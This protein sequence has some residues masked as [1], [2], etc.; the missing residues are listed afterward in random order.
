MTTV[1]LAEQVQPGPTSDS[2]PTG[3]RI[4]S[5][6]R[7]GCWICRDKKVKKKCDQQR[8]RC[9]RCV[10]HK[11]SCDYSPR[12]TLAERRRASQDIVIVQAA[13]DVPNDTTNLLPA[14]PIGLPIV[15]GAWSRNLST[16]DKEAIAYFRTG[17]AESHHTKNPDYGL[18]SL[19]FRIAQQEEMVMHM[20]IAIG[21]HEMDFRRLRPTA[22]QT[23][24]RHYATALRL[25]AVAITSPEKAKDTDSIYTTL[26]LMLLYEQQFGDAECRAYV[27]H[28]EGISSLLQHQGGRLLTL[29]PRKPGTVNRTSGFLG[30][31]T[32][33]ATSKMSVYSARVLVWIAL[34]DAAAASSGVG[35]QVNSTILALMIGDTSTPKVQVEDPVKTFTRLHRYS[36]SLYRTA[37]GDAYP[38]NELVDDVENR[39]IYALLCACAQLRFMTA[40]L[41]TIYRRGSPAAAQNSID[42]GNSIAEVGDLFVELLEVASELS[43]NTNN[44]HRLVAN[45][46]AIV[47]MYYAV[48]LDFDR[49]TA[50][51]EPLGERQQCAVEEIMNLACQGYEHDG[52]EAIIRVAWPLFIVALETDD[53]GHRKWILDRFEAISKFGKNFQRAHQFLLGAIPIQ[54]RLRVRIDLRDQMEK[55]AFF[56]LG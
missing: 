21:L 13:N 53:L 10:K 28:L 35:G 8:P 18:I 15:T 54:D 34:L 26:W 1:L 55:T 30:N 3:G 41:A 47:P 12:P 23:S 43:P 45:V 24:L 29:S 56:V 4:S 40:Q 37:W 6:S 11:L 31:S 36:N 52:D 14:S 32:E 49:L 27:H 19:M 25:M 2:P 5:R 51:D 9:G 42:V 16:E 39:S 33:K 20:V 22:R 38:Q 50:F 17:F 48:I 44:S 46:R 7:D